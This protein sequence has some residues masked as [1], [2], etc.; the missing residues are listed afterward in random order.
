MRTAISAL[1]FA[2]VT[3]ASLTVLAGA[4]AIEAR[5]CDPPV[6]AGGTGFSTDIAAWG[7]YRAGAATTTDP[8]RN[9]A[10]AFGQSPV[11][12]P[13]AYPD[14]FP[15][16]PDV[17]PYIGL[18][19]GCDCTCGVITCGDLNPGVSVGVGPGDAGWN[20]FAPDYVIATGQPTTALTLSGQDWIIA[21]VLFD[22]P[23]KSCPNDPCHVMYLLP[24]CHCECG[25]ITCGG[26]SIDRHIEPWS[27]SAL[28]R[29]A[30]TSHRF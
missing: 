5:N 27:P 8:A 7:L 15:C 25:V 21:P 26:L 12:P 2:V 23:G 22:P 17:C 11:F 19:Q 13:R 10:S 20:V 28:G 9:G 29:G 30:S 4:Q 1:M 16:H 3:L 18:P 24:G 6:A 14:I